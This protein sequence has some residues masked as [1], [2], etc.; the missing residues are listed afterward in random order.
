ML[1]LLARLIYCS[2]IRLRCNHGV[3]ETGRTKRF[4]LIS[5]NSLPNNSFFFLCLGKKCLKAFVL[6]EWVRERKKV[7]SSPAWPLYVVIYVFTRGSENQDM[8][9]YLVAIFLPP[10]LCGSLEKGQQA[11]NWWNS[12]GWAFSIS[13]VSCAWWVKMNWSI[14]FPHACHS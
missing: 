7:P 6:S 2:V 3:W 13:R 14:G 11:C 4:C 12:K 8:F 5:T 1:K 10:Y 9:Q